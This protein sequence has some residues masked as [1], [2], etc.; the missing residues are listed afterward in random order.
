M[1]VLCVS[2]LQIGLQ[3]H[4]V[5]ISPSV[6]SKVIGSNPPSGLAYH[7]GSFSHISCPKPLRGGT[8]TTLSLSPSKTFFK[9]NYVLKLKSLPENPACS[10]IYELKNVKL[11]QESV[12]KIPPLGIRI[13]P[14]LEKSKINLNLINDAS[15]VDIAPWT[16]SVPTVCF[17]LTK[18][19]KRYN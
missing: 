14:H 4:C 6:D 5:Q 19:L 16:L 2:L 9:L 12:S 18:F 15:S 7:A 8:W 10:C 1:P 3:M 13:L 17:D 11:F